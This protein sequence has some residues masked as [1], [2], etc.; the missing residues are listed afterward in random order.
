MEKSFQ[1]IEDS[2]TI[3]F[4]DTETGTVI[5]LHTPKDWD[6]EEEGEEADIL[7]RDLD[8]ED[9]ALAQEV[10]AHAGPGQRYIRIPSGESGWGDADMQDFIEQI[11]DYRLQMRLAQAIQRPGAFRRFRTIISHVGDLEKQWLVFRDA[12]HEERVK[13]WLEK[14][15]FQ[16]INLRPNFG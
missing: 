5:Y 14:E 11:L 7:L 15:G 2:P 6:E 3:D 16:L 13:K 12:R 8:E 1:E 10:H 9:I 4:L